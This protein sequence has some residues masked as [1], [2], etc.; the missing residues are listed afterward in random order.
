MS[1]GTWLQTARAVAWSFFGVRRRA[2]YEHD[3]QR[4]SPVQVV[5]VGLVGAAL[6]IAVLCFTP[7]AHAGDSKAIDASSET[8]FGMADE[9][10][11]IQGRID[12]VT[13][14]LRQGATEECLGLRTLA[15]VS[16]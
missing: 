6:F 9:R 15:D 13:F 3:V 11:G 2:D 1:G 16:V 7:S 8:A 12:R 14:L 5:V 4:L 10:C